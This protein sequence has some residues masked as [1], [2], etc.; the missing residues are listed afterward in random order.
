MSARAQAASGTGGAQGNASRIMR[1]EVNAMLR[2]RPV[3]LLL[4][5]L[6]AACGGRLPL[7]DVS[8][9]QAQAK[10]CARILE[11]FFAIHD[12][13]TLNRQ[14]P[15]WGHQS[16]SAIFCHS[17]AQREAAEAAKGKW[18]ASGR[19]RKP[20]VTEITPAEAFYPAE[21]YHQKYLMKRGQSSC[22]L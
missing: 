4:P 15:D 11:V 7:V 6:L 17:E 5:M 3:L 14:G 13:T 12:P 9:L 22:H 16:R 20:I 21:E 19:F 8:A 2:T 10:V 18:D 1:R